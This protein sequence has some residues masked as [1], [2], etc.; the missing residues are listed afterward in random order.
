MSGNNAFC[1]IVE[2]L[3][4]LS[5][6]KGGFTKEVNIVSWNEANPKLDI[7]IWLPNHQRA[8]S[9]LTFTEDEGYQLY[10]ALE[11]LYKDYK[12]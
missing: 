1:R 4:V 12:P 6:T 11:K 9:G 8:F 5:T 3:A 2:Q 7:R 10:Q